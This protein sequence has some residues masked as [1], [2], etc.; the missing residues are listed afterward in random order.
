MFMIAAACKNTVLVLEMSRRVMGTACIVERG[1]PLGLTVRLRPPP[2]SSP[3]VSS[4]MFAPQMMARTTMSR[5]SS[6]LGRDS[7]NEEET[8]GV[9]SLDR[10]V[11]C[12]RNIFASDSFFKGWESEHSNIFL[13]VLNEKSGE[14]LPPCCCRSSGLE[15]PR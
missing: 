9:S 10:M 1:S 6:E 5:D 3:T 13:S 11:R 14:H 2:C 4:L 15:P 7:N 8:T 12:A